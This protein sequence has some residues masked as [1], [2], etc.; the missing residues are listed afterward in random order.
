MSD[1]RD[2]ALDGDAAGTS[3]TLAEDDAVTTREDAEAPATGSTVRGTDEAPAVDEEPGAPAE[4]EP[5][6]RRR[7]RRTGKGSGGAARVS[8]PLVPVLAV[9]LV[10]LLAAGAYLWF[11]R[12]EGSNLRTD[13]Y[14]QAWAAARANMVDLTSYDHLTLDDDIRQ[15][16]RI[17]TGDLTEEATDRLDESRQEIL[18]TERVSSTK[19]VAAGVT[20][21]DDDEAT[22]MLVLEQTQKDNT[23]PQAQV[24]QYR[25][26]VELK[27]VDDRWL[28][29]AI[30]GA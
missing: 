29:S 25:V 30:R 5:A 14:S 9:L 16:S 10:L 8:L 15:I 19:V 28:L 4:D 21:A 23:N 1:A 13:D 20:R 17:T 22:V 24:A 27:K 11:T 26:E 18:D 7:G 12:P 2:R 6:P 3:T